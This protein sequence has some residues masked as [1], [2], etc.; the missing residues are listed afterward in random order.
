[1]RSK[2]QIIL[3]AFALAFVS[4]LL[5]SGNVV[6]KGSFTFKP[7][8]F[9]YAK[10]CRKKYTQLAPLN[11][12]D[13]KLS[14]SDGYKRAQA[15]V[16]GTPDIATDPYRAA[17][18]L[19]SIAASKDDKYANKAKIL[20]AKL[21]LVGNGVTK[22]EKKAITLL[23][24]AISY[25]PE[26]AGMSLGDYYQ[27][28]RQYER[29]EKYF[30]QAA[31]AGNAGAYVDLSYLY[32]N[33]LVTPPSADASDNM[34][35][36]AQNQLLEKLAIGHCNS[37]YTIGK[38]FLN[39]YY[40]AY[41]EQTALA[42]LKTGADANVR[43]SITTLAS[44]YKEGRG[45]ERNMRKA[46]ELWIRAANMGSRT[47]MYELG[48]NAL[49]HSSPPQ[50]DKAE[51]WLTLAAQSHHLQASE[52]LIEYYLGR[53]GTA[54][55]YD[56]A[57][58]WLNEVAKLPDVTQTSLFSLGE[59][60]ENGLGTQQDEAKA[61]SYYEQAANA[62]ST[63][64]LIKL[65]D[66]HKYGKGVKADPVHSY[67]FYRLAARNKSR[68][69]MMALIENYEC[70][71]GKAANPQLA[72]KWRDYAMYHGAVQVLHPYVRQLLKSTN[73][74]DHTEAVRILRQ[75]IEEERGA[76]SAILLALMYQ[77]GIGVEKNEDEA[78]QLL[79]FI[80]KSG[81]R[82]NQ[83][84]ALTELGKYS[85][86]RDEPYYDPERAL[87]SFKQA[88]ELGSA[89]AAYE[90]GKL[91]S[92]E[93]T[94]VP[95]SVDNAIIEFRYAAEQNYRA[96]MHKLGK[97]LVKKPDTQEEGLKWITQ[98]AHKQDIN[99]MLTLASFYSSKRHDY[100]MAKKWLETAKQHFPCKDSQKA[101][102][103]ELSERII[104]AMAPEE[105]KR[106][107]LEQLAI[108]G[109]LEAMRKLAQYYFDHAVTSDDEARYKKQGLEWIQKAANQGDAKAMFELA[110]MYAVGLYVPRSTTKANE[111]WKKAAAAGHAE[112]QALLDKQ[113]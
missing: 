14:L 21:Y 38:L 108:K 65:G 100:E 87:V 46:K 95:Q 23:E 29:A 31:V 59:L 54:P 45:V 12:A 76:Q 2:P 101:R 48:A 41:D 30:K 9:D 83:A 102:L 63:A 40:Q 99:A 19:K 82:E 113:D 81:P 57:Y 18:I 84:E 50:F 64:A 79:D 22:D 43:S 88:K 15:L 112:A 67:R 56:K 25:F 5:P 80:T 97:L 24:Q 98:A 39:E 47:A 34:L 3:F 85:L 69:A 49:L 107:M 78:V 103:S 52:L 4:T 36:L 33:K 35:K 90:L 53:Y 60:Y 1:M 89:E 8:T 17:R 16:K 13:S 109:D 94:I 11:I 74:R 68:D 10:V 110:N 26:N 20:L 104:M 72:Q 42:W 91:Y 61:F 92:S 96:A 86:Q 51:K 66:A 77:Y 44:L 73:P 27:A 106:E 75:R 58:E 28:N 7:P 111:W 37:L 93:N 55:Q 71:I 105:E 62:G 6:A 70:G 32:R